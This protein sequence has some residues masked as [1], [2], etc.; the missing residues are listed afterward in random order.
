METTDII[1]DKIIRLTAGNVFTYAVF[2]VPVNLK[3][4]F[5]RS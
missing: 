3:L 4:I 5:T 2:E 1:N